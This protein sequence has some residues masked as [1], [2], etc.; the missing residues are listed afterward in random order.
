MN[1]N[2]NKSVELVCYGA[3]NQTKK[4]FTKNQHKNSVRDESS[5]ETIRK[6]NFLRKSLIEDVDCLS[7]L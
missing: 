6:S 1:E 2:K 7:R 3:L 5:W 4:R